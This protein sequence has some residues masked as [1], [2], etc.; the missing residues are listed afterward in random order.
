MIRDCKPYDKRSSMV[1]TTCLQ[2]RNARKLYKETTSAVMKGQVTSLH[3]T[4]TR[5]VHF[6]VPYR[7]PGPIELASS[8]VQEAIIFVPS[9][10]VE[11]WGL[12]R[13]CIGALLFGP[14]AHAYGFDARPTPGVNRRHKLGAGAGE[15]KSEERSRRKDQK[16]RCLWVGAGREIARRDVLC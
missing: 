1:V 15:W 3:T 4:P 16:S 7:F 2:R 13:M 12:G 5:A 6:H 8:L 14:F 11:G 9:C 10:S